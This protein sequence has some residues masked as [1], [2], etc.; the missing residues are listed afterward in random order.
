M[1][2][3]NEW[4]QAHMLWRPKPWEEC[5]LVVEAGVIRLPFYCTAT[6]IILSQPQSYKET[7]KASQTLRLVNCNG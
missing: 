7:E 5:T 4:A 2:S 3:D 6:P 1:R